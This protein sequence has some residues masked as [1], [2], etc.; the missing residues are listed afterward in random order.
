MSNEVTKNFE[1]ALSKLNTFIQQGI[2]DE[3]D[4]AGLIQGFEFTFEQAWKALQKRGRTEG[5]TIASPKQAFEWAMEQGWI[6]STDEQLWLDMLKDR[7]LTSH[8]YRESVA[9]DVAENIL[10]SYGK[11][12]TGLLKALG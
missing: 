11:A 5:I 2:V 6:P 10:N 9:K 8:T 4:R 1:L 12:L 3:L 7:N